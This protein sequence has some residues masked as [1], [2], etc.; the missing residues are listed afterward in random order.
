MVEIMKNMS[1]LK[2]GVSAR[3]GRMLLGAVWLLLNYTGDLHAMMPGH[4]H[5]G[6]T[7]TKSNSIF[8][9]WGSV[10]V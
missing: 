10:V 3:A 5:D 9:G 7:S 4:D 1:S 8:T 6:K 2:N